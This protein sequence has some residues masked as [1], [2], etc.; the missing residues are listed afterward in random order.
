MENLKWIKLNKKGFIAENSKSILGNI[1]GI[2]AYRLICDKTKIYIAWAQNLSQRFRQHRY[3]YSIYKGNNSK[4]YNMI[5]K[6]GWNNIEYT[7]L[8]ILKSISSAKIEK[9]YF[10]G[11]ITKVSGYIFSF[12]KYL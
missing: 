12:F 3:R 11:K 7:I 6:Y 9:K 2:Y 8:E 4:Y 1:A 10:N 5:N